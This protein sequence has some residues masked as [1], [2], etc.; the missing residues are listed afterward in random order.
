MDDGE[1]RSGLFEIHAQAG[2]QM[3]EVDGWEAPDVFTSV[4]TE[5][6]AAHA[7]AVIY[8]ASPLGRLRL[9]G[10]TRLDF[11]QRMSTNDL[12]G[13]QPGQGAATIL[14]TPIARIIDRL[15]VYVR[16]NDVLLLT[17]RGAQAAVA[18]WLKK[19]IFFNDDVQVRDAS[20][21]YAMLSLYGAR[22]SE[23]ASRIAQQNVADL[24]LHAWR[25]ID[26]G[27]LIA[28][29]DPIAGDG[30]HLLT[31][32]ATLAAL[33]RAALQAGAIA[34]GER[35]FEMLRIESGAP[36]YGRELSAAYIPLEVGLWA[37]VS[38]SKGC[39]IG[40][41]IIARMESR[42]RLAKQLIGLRA[43]APIEPG[44]DILADGSPIGV[45]SS[46]VVRPDGDAIGLG[47]VKPVHASGDARVTI[48]GDRRV[49]AHIAKFPID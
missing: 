18:N 36:R 30:F 7:G 26:D 41:E 34:I 22:A 4:E 11:L 2:A 33:W 35:A 32:E 24:G 39:Y 48:G 45:V 28:R 49:D 23:V 44:A 43:S 1:M 37:D 27:G 19:Y 15:I 13:L 16:A 9:T 46:A 47:F 10:S 8:D 12:N 29:A 31:P 5:Y 6:R 21:E 25:P 17:S 20:G 14:T 3:V 38:F 42:Q 40:Q